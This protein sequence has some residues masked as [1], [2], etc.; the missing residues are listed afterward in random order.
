MILYVNG[1]SHT[2]AA[3]ATNP[4]AFAEDD[5]RYFY[6]GRAPHPDNLKVSWGKLLSES[7]QA[8]F[9]CDAESASSNDRILRTTREWINT[10]YPR[11]NDEVIVIIQWSTWE[12]EEWL[13][14]G[15]YYQIN[16]SGIDIVPES[17]QEQYK[18]F[19]STVDWK[20]KTQEAYQKIWELHQELL[21]KNIK[22]I[23]FN[24][25]NDFSSIPLSARSD[26]K[27]DK[28]WERH[29]IGPYDSDQT[30]DSI[31]R[32]SGYQ[33]VSPDSWHFGRD[34]HGFWSRYM[35][36]YILQHNFV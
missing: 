17:H 29:Y 30:F 3:E 24:G 13:I 15:E 12:R 32:N 11:Y 27:G 36:Q 28:D 16:A 22:H 34:A 10:T 8:G 14:D 18:E 9:H 6:K 21:D 25:N 35:L 2:A 1:D 4:H 23:F 19:V 33:T 26:I 20:Q 5:G 7:L 31:L